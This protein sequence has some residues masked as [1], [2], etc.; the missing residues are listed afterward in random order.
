MRVDRDRYRVPAS[1]AGQDVSVRRT[2]DYVHVVAD[3]ELI[4]ADPRRYGRDQ[5]MPVLGKKPGA[6]RNGAP[7]IAWELPSQIQLVHDLILRQP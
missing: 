2:A 6:L 4:A 7:F 3:G 5:L 1:A